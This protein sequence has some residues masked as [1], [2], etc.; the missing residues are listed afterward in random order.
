MKWLS[1]VFLFVLISCSNSK[2]EN[3]FSE[4]LAA[5]PYSRLT[6]SIKRFPKNDDLYF[7]R[8]VLL[9][10]NNQP[11]PAL[12]DFHKAWSLLKLEQ[13]AVGIS[14]I[15]IDAKPDSAVNFLKQATTAL[16]ESM[17]L[18]LTLARAYNMEGAPDQ[19]LAVCNTILATEPNQVNALILKADILEAKDDKAGMIQTLE[20]AHLLLP[21]NIEVSNRLAYQYAEAR[22]VK[23]ISLAD[24]L[25]RQDSLQ[26]HPEPYYIKGNYYSN[27]GDKTKAIFFFDET[28]K[29]DHRFQNAYIEKGKALLDQNKTTEAFRTFQLANTINPAFP[30]AWYWMGRC[31]EKLGQ[32]AEARDNYEKAIG[33]DKNF[34]DAK[35][36]LKNL[37]N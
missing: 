35:D 19:A 36:A 13:Y 6:D 26:L 21:A 30:D 1:P 23:A 24:S 29:H 4:L 22:D 32:K 33:L 16:P 20:H 15:L 31:Q 17:Y 28:I 9:N 18:Q 25:I 12:A 5:P 34:T 8:A 7:R 37:S 2:D 27:T 3:A 10:R 11:E 14:N